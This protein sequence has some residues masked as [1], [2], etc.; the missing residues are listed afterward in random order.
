M[1]LTLEEHKETIESI[2]KWLDRQDLFI[3]SL[4]RKGS[5]IALIK[6]LARR[7]AEQKRAHEFYHVQYGAAVT[8]RL[9]GFDRT[10]FLVK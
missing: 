8:G 5:N 2:D 3:K 10:N 7:L 1:N 6:N 9:K 4:E